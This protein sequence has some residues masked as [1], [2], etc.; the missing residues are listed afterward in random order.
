MSLSEESPISPRGTKPPIFYNL[1]IFAITGRIKARFTFFRHYDI[2]SQTYSIRFEPAINGDNRTRY[3]P[4][5]A[6]KGTS[7]DFQS[8][9]FSGG[10]YNYCAKI[11]PCQRLSAAIS[12][13]NNRRCPSSKIITSSPTLP[14]PW[15]Y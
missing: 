2:H 3:C 15:I 1:Y 4:S 5:T 10:E 13:S 14:M 12:C 6:K 8:V 11:N 7:G 9:P